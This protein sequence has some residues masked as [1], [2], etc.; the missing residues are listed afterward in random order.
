VSTPSD[1]TK[2]RDGTQLEWCWVLAKAPAGHV[3]VCPPI[4][5]EVACMGA[6]SPRTLAARGVLGDVVEGGSRDTGLVK[7]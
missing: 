1:T 3:V 4:T 5:H 2:S 6:L 7:F